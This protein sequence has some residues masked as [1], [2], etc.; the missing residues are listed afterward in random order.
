MGD[1]VGDTVGSELVGDCDGDTVG[2]VVVGDVEGDMVG[3]RVQPVQVNLQF[4]R[5]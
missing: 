5:K 4:A 3:D 1:K 2:S